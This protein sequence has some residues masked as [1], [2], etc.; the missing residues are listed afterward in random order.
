MIEYNTEMEKDLSNYLDTDKKNENQHLHSH[1]MF[2]TLL[3]ER[4]ECKHFH[5]FGTIRNIYRKREK[6]TEIRNRIRL[7]ANL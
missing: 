2:L 5:T 1:S 7:S 3:L 6:V 4:I